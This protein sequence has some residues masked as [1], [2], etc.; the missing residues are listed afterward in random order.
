MP[1]VDHRCPVGHDDYLPRQRVT[2]NSD[3]GGCNASKDYHR[4]ETSRRR[5]APMPSEGLGNVGRGWVWRVV[6][7][8]TSSGRMGHGGK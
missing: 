7:G 6:G 4:R 3:L 5:H 8:Y 1:K 2:H